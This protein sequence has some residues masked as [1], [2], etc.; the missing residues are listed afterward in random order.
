LHAGF[1]YTR[2][3]HPILRDAWRFAR[4]RVI[5]SGME[6]RPDPG[7]SVSVRIGQTLRRYFVAGLAALFPAAATVY[8]VAGIFRFSDG[9]LG[10]YLA[11][12]IPGLGIFLTVLIL[13]LVGFFST[14]F[15]GRVV[16]PTIE[17]W[18]SRLPLIRFIY[19]AIKQLTQ[20]LLNSDERNSTLKQV[21]LVR[22]PGPG[23]Y[24]LAFVIHE[25]QSS[26]TGT[27]ESLLTLLI[28]T[29]PSPFSGPLI[30]LPKKEV[31]PLTMSI[32]EAVKLVLSGGI[33][34]TPLE[35][36]PKIV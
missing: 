20:S 8:L 3:F 29:P 19:P 13:L 32:E 34:S 7:P 14:H 26:V 5:L 12:H 21:V 16:F 9:L 27:P 17:V 22:Y 25:E 4:T 30:F 2:T 36:P 1:Y 18:F 6:Q 10:R 33:V 24:S 15:F 35:T 11:V 23:I 28:P 31:L